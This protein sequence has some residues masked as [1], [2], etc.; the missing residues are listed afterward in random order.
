MFLFYLLWIVVVGFGFFLGGGAVWTMTQQG[1]SATL[2][3]NAV[4]YLGSAL[5]GVPRFIKLL[6]G[7]AAKGH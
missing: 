2:V 7:P 1:V 3:V 6:T 5:Y 4:L